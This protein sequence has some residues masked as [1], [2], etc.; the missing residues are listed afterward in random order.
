MGSTSNGNGKKNGKVPATAIGGR[1][2]PEQALGIVRHLD[3]PSSTDYI[4]AI[5]DDF[6][7]LK[8]DRVSG[9]DVTIVGGLG[10]LNGERVVVIGQERRSVPEGQKYHSYPEGF[11]KARRLVDLA[12]RF[13]LPVV[14]LIDTQGAHSGLE[15]EEQGVGNA[16]A[17]TLSLM[18]QVPTPVVSVIIGE[19]GSEAA[20]APGLGD[21]ILM[22]RYAIFSPISRDRAVSR[23]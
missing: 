13:K 10:Y 21:T 4:E 12:A 17:T 19:G 14:T 11:R 6:I 8:G 16:I 20:L 3:R 18:A 9:D 15:S 23:L 2:E 7:E 1:V 22:Q 5:V